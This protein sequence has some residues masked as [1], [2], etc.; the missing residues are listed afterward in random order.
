MQ[1]DIERNEEGSFNRGSTSNIIYK[2]IKNLE[3]FKDGMDISSWFTVLEIFLKNFRKDQW[4][5]IT[6]SNIENKV[7]RKLKYL[8][9]FLVS[10]NRYEEL[11]K[12]LISIYKV[13]SVETS[14]N[15]SKLS[16]VKQSLNESISGFGRSLIEMVNKFFPSVNECNDIDKIM[17]ERFAEG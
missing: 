15:F 4:V 11:K 9:I 14:I 2:S 13:N 12:E 10:T 1:L 7:L 8:T 5:E 17:Q 16:M 3:E 6:L